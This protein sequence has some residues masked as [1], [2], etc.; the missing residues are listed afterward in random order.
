[1]LIK[2]E[3]SDA[4]EVLTEANKELI[5]VARRSDESVLR[6]RN[7]DGLSYESW[8]SDVVRDGHQM[9]NRA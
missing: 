7:Y 2:V 5:E 3:N 1:M 9:S 6:Q 4:S 8:M